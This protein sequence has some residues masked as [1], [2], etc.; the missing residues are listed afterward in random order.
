MDPN[1]RPSPPPPH[2]P[3]RR[4]WLGTTIALLVLA[5]VAA[6]AWHLTHRT[7]SGAGARAASAAGGGGPGGPG[8]PGGPGGGRGGPPTTVGIATAERS[9]LPVWVESLGTVVPA[10]N[11]TVRPQVSG[12]LKQVLYRE[13][14]M[15]RAG[16]VLA[17]IDPA[18]FQMALMQARGQRLRDEAQLQNARLTLQ[19]YQTLLQQDSIARQDVDTQA[20]L[21][22][23]LEATI[24]SDKAAEGTAQLNLNYTKITAPISGRIGLRPVDPGNLVSTSDTNGVATITQVTPIDVS[25]NLPQDRVPDVQARLA[26]GTPMNAIALDRGRVN[27]LDQGRFL[28][29][30]N[31]IDVQTGTVKAKAR[32]ANAKGTLFPNQFVNLR[33]LLDTVSGAVTVPVT[34]VRQRT[35]GDYVYVLNADRS[36][37]LRPVTRGMATVDKVAITT[38]LQPGE[39]VVTEGADRLRDGA[40]VVLPSDRPASGAMRGAR[41]ASGAALGASG[42]S[43]AWGGRRHRASDAAA[44][45]SA[46]P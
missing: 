8:R 10:A 41:G 23:Q 19:R 26:Q 37:H 39:R 16:Q 42:A 4:R 28:T 22:H 36:V 9:D 46:S 11:V 1:A 6:L 13:G 45:A 43:G 17:L 24:V 29:M 38:G 35:Q 14:D 27:E 18:S 20:A 32:F 31:Q 25:F 40:R 34:A 30:D 15:V 12:V 33:L 5:A 2:H 21:V 44:G 3:P 7:P